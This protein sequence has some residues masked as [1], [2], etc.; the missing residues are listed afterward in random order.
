MLLLAL[1]LSFALAAPA[2]AVRVAYRVA[3]IGAGMWVYEYGLDGFS[4]EAGYGFTVYFDPDL[5]ADLVA[6]PAPNA[7]WDPLAV[8]PDPDLGEDGFLD[9][10]ALS[11][12]PS[13]SDGFLVAFR[14]LGEGTPGAQ[15]FEV[16]EPAPSFGTVET[17]TTILPE[18]SACGL[19]LAALGTLLATRRSVG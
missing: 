15:P 12:Q 5:Y 8:E 3:P 18:P 2:R 17:G 11:D 14:W 19:G 10:E 4:Y 7:D 13:V 16:R 9:A 1:L 6:A